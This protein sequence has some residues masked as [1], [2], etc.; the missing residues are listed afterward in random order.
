MFLLTLL[1]IAQLV[2]CLRILDRVGKPG[3]STQPKDASAERA[4]RLIQLET[5]NAL[6][7]V[8][9]AAAEPPANKPAHHYHWT[10]AP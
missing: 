9:E 5:A 7:A 4:I 3:D 1:S 2:V 10:S 8:S 6:R